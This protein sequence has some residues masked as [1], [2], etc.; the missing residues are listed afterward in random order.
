MADAPQQLLARR[1]HGVVTSCALRIQLVRPSFG[2]DN[3]YGADGHTPPW[4]FDIPRAP[5]LET[6]D[7]NLT[8]PLQSAV[9]AHL[10]SVP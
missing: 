8:R 1:T 2:V 4:N 9:G 10:P 7:P 6:A 3:A 5:S